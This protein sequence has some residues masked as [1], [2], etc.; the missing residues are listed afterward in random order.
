TFAGAVVPARN[1]LRIIPDEAVS[2]WPAQTRLPALGDAPPARQLDETLRAIRARYGARTA[3]L[4]AMQLEYP[5]GMA[6]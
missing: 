3:N 2:D 5:R 1:G 6:G 4:V